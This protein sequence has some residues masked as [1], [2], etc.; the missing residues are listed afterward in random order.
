MKT[1]VWIAAGGLVVCGFLVPAGELA[2]HMGEPY[3]PP[4]VHTEAPVIVRTVD[5]VRVTVSGQVWTGFLGHRALFAC[6]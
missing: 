3:L 6:R 2:A 5:V 1:N 4:H